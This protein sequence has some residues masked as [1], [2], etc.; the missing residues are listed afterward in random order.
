MDI[1]LAELETGVRDNWSGYKPTRTR[2]I[3]TKWTKI[4]EPIC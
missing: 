2:S 4:S 3:W 1:M